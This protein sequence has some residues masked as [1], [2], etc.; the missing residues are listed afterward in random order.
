[1]TRLST[2]FAFDLQKLLLALVLAGTSV[3][4]L[5]ACNTVEGAGEDIE[6][7]GEVIQDGADND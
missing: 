3:L 5:S 6:S 7:A 1:M 4:A 2:G